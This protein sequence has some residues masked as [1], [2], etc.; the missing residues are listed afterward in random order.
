[1]STFLV[2]GSSHYNEGGVKRQNLVKMLE[3]GNIIAL[4][5]EPHNTEDPLAVAVHSDQGMIGYVPKKLAKLMAKEID[6]GL[7]LAAR[8]T[9]ISEPSKMYGVVSVEVELIEYAD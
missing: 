3:V 4:V 9:D 1:M 8:V 6:E 2:R 7:R 5:R